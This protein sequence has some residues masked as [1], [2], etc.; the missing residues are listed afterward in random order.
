MTVVKCCSEGAAVFFFS[1]VSSTPV[2]R[3]RR[4]RQRIF[5]ANMP[6]PCALLSAAPNEIV[7]AISDIMDSTAKPWHARAKA[8][9]VN[10]SL[11]DLDEWPRKERE[12]FFLRGLPMLAP[13]ND[14]S[15]RPRFFA[16][17]R[18]AK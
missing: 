15:I 4:T 16:A 3:L 11:T 9:K 5:P 14:A 6:A 18:P 13:E 2:L 1:R 7:A 17:L 12:M 8:A 10:D